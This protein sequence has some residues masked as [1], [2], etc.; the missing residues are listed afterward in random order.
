[1]AEIFL[2]LKLQ[3]LTDTPMIGL[4][5]VINNEH[6]LIPGV[7]LTDALIVTEVRDVHDSSGLFLKKIKG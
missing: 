3:I 4:I 2:A 1:M 5:I 6:F 7:K